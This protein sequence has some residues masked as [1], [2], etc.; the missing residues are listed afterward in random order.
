MK[1][2]SVRDIFLRL[3]RLVTLGGLMQKEN[4]KSQWIDCV[5]L[6]ASFHARDLLQF[7]E[8]EVRETIKKIHEGNECV[9][10]IIE[11]CRSIAKVYPHE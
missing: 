10:Y 4:A 8:D 1:N 2:N 7:P 6:E 3:D 9:E 11:T 5:Y